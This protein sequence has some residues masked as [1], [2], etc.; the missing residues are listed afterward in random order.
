ML[1]LANPGKWPLKEREMVLCYLPYCHWKRQEFILVQKVV[2]LSV[3]LGHN[4]WHRHWLCLY[5]IRSSE[6][7]MSSSQGLKNVKISFRTCLLDE[8]SS[9]RES[10]NRQ[11][12]LAHH[13][14]KCL[15]FTDCQFFFT[16]G[17]CNK[18]VI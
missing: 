7:R 2:T 9:T 15:P 1:V 3:L 17:L 10:K 18:R 11:H 8:C 12:A 14:A 4:T 13:I 16:I 6:G 5:H